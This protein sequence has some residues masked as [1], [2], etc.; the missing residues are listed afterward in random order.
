MDSQ[1]PLEQGSRASSAETAQIPADRGEHVDSPLRKRPRLNHSPTT[2]AAMAAKYTPPPPTQPSTTSTISPP[3]TPLQLTESALNNRNGPMLVKTPS[4]V[5]LN[6]RASRRDSPH[7]SSDPD[8]EPVSEVSSADRVIFDTD[9]DGPT[10]EFL[11][12]QDSIDIT[13]DSPLSGSQSPPVVEIEVDDSEDI[14]N[15]TYPVLETSN[16]EARWLDK[17]P[18]AFDHGAIQSVNMLVDAMSTAG[19]AAALRSDL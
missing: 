4:R 2:D 9:R 18:H 13:S 10:R 14:E 12:D 11:L 1:R 19:T 6:L 3:S 16:L 17:F 15:E 8:A 7:S 5:T